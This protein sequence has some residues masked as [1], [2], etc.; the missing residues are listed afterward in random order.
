MIIIF[1]IYFEALDYTFNNADE[2]MALDG[3][4]YTS[5][6]YV[7]SMSIFLFI[8]SF[9]FE[10][11]NLR[12]FERMENAFYRTNVIPFINGI[13]EIPLTITYGGLLPFLCW[14][15]FG[16]IVVF[17]SHLCNDARDQLTPTSI[18]VLVVAG[19][20]LYQVTADFSEY[21]T[22]SRQRIAPWKDRNVN[23]VE[24]QG[25]LEEREM[26]LE[27]ERRRMK[28]EYIDKVRRKEDAI[29]ILERS[30]DD[31]KEEWL[32]TADSAMKRQ[33]YDDYSRLQDLYH[34]TIRKRTL[35]KE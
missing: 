29:R 19:L 17:S 8:H 9:V 34:D 5:T 6:I 24:Q 13:M 30:M 14:L 28:R 27:E 35:E 32:A 4:F 1:A 18:Q 20:L 31:A 11:D 15:I 26:I 33:L 2:R 16:G 25:N 23:D 21:W 7:G 3:V 22:Q 10:E 12:T